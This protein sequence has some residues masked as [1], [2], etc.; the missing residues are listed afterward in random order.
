MAQYQ[1]RVVSVISINEAV[2][3]ELENGRCPHRLVHLGENIDG[4]VSN[5]DLTLWR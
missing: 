3:D 5:V 1:C 4:K 2:M